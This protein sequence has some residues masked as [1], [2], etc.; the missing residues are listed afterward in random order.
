MRT[1]W[2]IAKQRKPPPQR[3]RW[4]ARWSRTEGRLLRL[5]RSANGRRDIHA[6]MTPYSPIL[7]YCNL[8]Y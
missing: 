3:A 1:D 2:G 6:R 8:L 4:S 7:Y 5:L